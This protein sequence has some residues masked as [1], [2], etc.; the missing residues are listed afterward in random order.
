MIWFTKRLR[1]DGPSSHE[2]GTN[3]GIYMAAQRWTLL[4]SRLTKKAG[5]AAYKA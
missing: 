4:Q 3:P 5:K 2:K 1:N